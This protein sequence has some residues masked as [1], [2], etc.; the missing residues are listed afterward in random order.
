MTMTRCREC[1]NTVA[2]DQ[3]CSNCQAQPALGQE[4]SSISEHTALAAA[5]GFGKSGSSPSRRHANRTTRGKNTAQLSL[6]QDGSAP[7]PAPKTLPLR[8]VPT[9]T[10]ADATPVDE[11]VPKTKPTQTP[12][13]LASSI[14][15]QDLWPLAPHSTIIR[16][17]TL[18]L[19]LFTMA[20]GLGLETFHLPGLTAG[21]AGALIA[22]LAVAPISDRTRSIALIS[23]T[24]LAWAAFSQWTGTQ[25]NDGLANGDLASGPPWALQ[26]PQFPLMSPLLGLLAGALM[27]RAQ[28]RASTISRWMCGIASIGAILV[29]L[30]LWRDNFY[31]SLA[32]PWSELWEFPQQPSA[33]ILRMGALAMLGLLAQLAFLPSLTSAG[34]GFWAWGLLTWNALWLLQHTFTEHWYGRVPVHSLRQATGDL[35]AISFTPIL[36]LAIFSLASSFLGRPRETPTSS[37][38]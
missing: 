2:A 38:P 24:G 10:N 20:I 19:G 5:S 18:A 29:G 9:P 7:T 16:L 14:L 23:I 8:V 4:R 35:L 31:P 27:V 30:S 34:A 26:G 17:G 15:R 28:Y 21:L 36:A 22:A 1:G 37:D 33:G 11:R 32:L 25:A 6:L 3:P 12:P 13:Y